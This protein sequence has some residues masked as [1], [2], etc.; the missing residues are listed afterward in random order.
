VVDKLEIRRKAI[1]LFSLVIPLGYG[2]ASKRT[3]MISLVGITAFF[4]FFDVIRHYSQPIRRIY[5]RYLIGTVVRE[6]EEHRFIGSTYFLLGACL[7]VFLFDK[8]L[9]ILSLLVL[10]ISDTV[11]AFVGGT[12]GRTRIFGTKTLEGSTAFFLSASL[13]ALL[14]PGIRP[15]V[16]LPAAFMATLAECLPFR[17]D[18]NL[19]IPLVMGFSIQGFSLLE[20]L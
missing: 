12:I 15:I 8:R 11:A 2:L 13:I 18:D 4:F 14:S 9:A 20:Q 10:I 16:G 5:E 7:S 3:A 19:L 1:H 17:I 6:K